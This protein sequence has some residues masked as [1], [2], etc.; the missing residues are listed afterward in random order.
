MSQRLENEL[1]ISVKIQRNHKHLTDKLK[2]EI[3]EKDEHIEVT[4]F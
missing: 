2:Q 4:Y 3:K 1:D